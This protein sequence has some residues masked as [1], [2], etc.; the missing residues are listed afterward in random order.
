[1]AGSPGNKELISTGLGP[2]AWRAANS[3]TYGYGHLTVFNSTHAYWEWEQ[4]AA[5]IENIRNRAMLLKDYLWIVQHNHT[6]RT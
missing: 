2:A 5:A 3:L 1:V 4:T 6:T